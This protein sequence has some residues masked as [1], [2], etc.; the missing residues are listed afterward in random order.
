[1]LIVDAHLD[2]SYN[3][4]GGRDILKPASEQPL[5]GN[6][7]ATVGLPDLHAGS[8][9]LVCATVFTAPSIDGGSGYRT[10]DEAYAQ[11]REHLAYYQQQESAGTFRFIRWREDLPTDAG[12]EVPR[13]AGSDAPRALNAIILMEGADPLRT[14]AD[15]AAWYEAGLRIVGMAWKQT[16]YAG[17]TGDPGPLT[18]QG[19]A[20]VPVLDRFK[21]IHDASHL[22]EESFWQLLDLTAGPIMASHSNCRS[23][24]PTDRQLSDEMIRAI[25]ARGGVIGINFFDRFLLP[26]AEHGSRRA[27]L[28]DVIHHMKHICELAGDAQHVGIGT[29]MDGGLGRNEIPH[30]IHT[31]ADLPKLQD[32]LSAADFTDSDITGIMGGNWLDFFGRSLPTCTFKPTS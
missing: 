14:P 30:E 7:I 16:R 12:S 22:A 9:G 1:M 23:I 31:S 8:V 28:A 29:D 3:A 17:G 24:V 18:P 4:L 19:V 11:G 10:A 27:N 26:P 32:A 13:R 25:T 21:I 15:L 6:Q 20:L 5:S 2:L